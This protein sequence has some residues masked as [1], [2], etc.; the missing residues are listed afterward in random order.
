MLR[1]FAAIALLLVASSARALECPPPGYDGNADCGYQCG[2]GGT[3]CGNPWYRGTTEWGTWKPD[4]S[5]IVPKAV[6][7]P[8]KHRRRLLRPEARPPQSSRRAAVAGGG[9]GVARAC[10]RGIFGE[11]ENCTSQW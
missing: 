10:R 1:I 8:A 9:I 2:E 4:P 5:C 6:S 7:R 11:W 3:C